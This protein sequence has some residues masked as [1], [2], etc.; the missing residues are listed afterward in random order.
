MSCP[1]NRPKVLWSFLKNK[2]KDSQLYSS[3]SI[4]TP[5][6]TAMTFFA[7]KGS[8]GKVFVNLI[9]NIPEL[10]GSVT[11]QKYSK[12]EKKRV[13]VQI[14]T[15]V[16]HYSDSHGSVDT[17]KGME[18]Y[19][20]AGLREHHS[21]KVEIHESLTMLMIAASVWYKTQ[22]NIKMGTRDYILRVLPEIRER[23]PIQHPEFHPTA[24][25][26][27]LGQVITHTLGTLQSQQRCSQCGKG[28]VRFCTV[29]PDHPSICGKCNIPFHNP[30]L[31]FVNI[32][33]NV[34]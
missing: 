14:P 4:S 6:L 33:R 8:G 27:E 20:R 31:T 21:Y 16:K 10:T 28:T 29:C 12:S 34:E 32:D 13:S 3:I 17:L 23:K 18:H 7:R 1:A 15:M 9:T 25:Q 24:S 19:C 30:H 5:R 2:L 26:M 11:V 22:K